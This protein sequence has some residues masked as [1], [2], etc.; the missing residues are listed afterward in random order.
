MLSSEVSYDDATIFIKARN[1]ISRFVLFICR[2]S[3]FNW[4][5]KG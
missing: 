5:M 1:S 4:K 2:G 3:D